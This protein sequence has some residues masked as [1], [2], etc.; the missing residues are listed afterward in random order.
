M[1]GVLIAPRILVAPPPE[2]SGPLGNAPVE[3]A[4]TLVA[5]GARALVLRDVGAM[6][7]RTDPGRMRAIAEGV[8]RL[9]VP[10]TYDA[11]VE[12]V[13]LMDLAAALPVQF[14]SV[15]QLAL[16]DGVLGRWAV[17]LLGARCCIE[18]ALDGDYLFDPPPGAFG[19]SANEAAER[20]L[21]LGAP[22]ILVRDITGTE[23]PLRVL[24]HLADEVALPTY[25]SG[26]VRTLSDI[27][28]L[29]VVGS[30]NLRQVFVGD[31][32][33]DGSIRL[34]EANAIADELAP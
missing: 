4:R 25:F 19:L 32:V 11:A 31:P 33:F 3:V 1:R 2:G 15:G 8:S 28:E 30:G 18:M 17:D 12:D 21:T 16:V 10:V 29:R 5:G 6:L 9:G 20:M 14:V 23:L 26:R 22:T 27:R 24:R 7:A 34:A 13:D